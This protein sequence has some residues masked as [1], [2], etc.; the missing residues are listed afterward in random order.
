M[1]TMLSATHSLD[2]VDLGLGYG[3][4]QVIRSLDLEIPSGRMTAIVGANASCRGSG[5]T[6]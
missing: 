1:T 4:R 3:D 6:P 2:V 5:S